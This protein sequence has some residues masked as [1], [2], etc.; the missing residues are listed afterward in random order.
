MKWPAWFPYPQSWFRAVLQILYLVPVGYVYRTLGENRSFMEFATKSP[1]TL[2]FLILVTVLLPFAAVAWGN[3]ILVISR[4]P[5]YWPKRLPSPLSLWE[6][7][8]SVL[9][10]LLSL[11]LIFALL[12]FF[13][14][15]KPETFISEQMGIIYF[16]FA[17][18][19]FQADYLIR[20]GM[21][22]TKAIEP[23][24]TNVTTK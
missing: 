18:Y 21:E 22:D 3:D 1:Q 8:F 12:L 11:V 7:L 6:G 14:T 4:K 9:I 19:M 10:L 13:Y 2:G 15:G 24:S 20:K 16:V 23:T 5:T 17:A